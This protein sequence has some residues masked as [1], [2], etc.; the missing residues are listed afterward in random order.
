LF[1]SAR[2]AYAADRTVTN[3]SNDVQL[4]QYLGEIQA[5]GGGT[6]SF[7]CGNATI[8][9]TAALPSITTDTIVNAGNRITISGNNS[10]RIFY[11]APTGKLRLYNITLTR[12]YAAGDGGAIYNDGLLDINSSKFLDNTAS[13]S[14]GAIV[15]YGSVFVVG[16]EFA[17]NKGANGGAIYPRHAGGQVLIS[18]S[19][20][21]HNETTSATDGWGGAILIWNS[22]KVTI[23]NSRVDDNK[24][25]SGGGVYVRSDATLIAD[26]SS[27]NFNQATAYSGGAVFNEA[28]ATITNSTMSNNTAASSGG[29]LE[30]YLNGVLSLT[31]VTLSSNAANFGGGISNTKANGTLTNV[32]ITGNYASYSGGGIDNGTYAGEGL[33]LKNTIVANSI[34]GGNCHDTNALTINTAGFNLSSDNTCT[35][36]FDQPTDKNNTDPLLSGL[37]TNGGAT[38][39]HLPSR[40]SPAVNQGTGSGAPS[41]D[42]RGIPRPQGTAVDIGAVEVCAKP[43]KPTL[44][45]PKNGKKV[46]KTTFKLDWLDSICANKYKVQVR[47]GSSTGPI[48]FA[49]KEGISEAVAGTF[50]KGKTYYWQ[51]TGIGNGKSKSDWWSF[52]IKP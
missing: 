2:P 14:G 4:H 26:G 28:A 11:V 22:A 19:N 50:V 16:S 29:A 38:L 24:A 21:H 51:V 47:D 48:V 41:A 8:L 7:N 27:F 6:L 13:A 1:L 20:L 33:T 52:T 23:L 25:R 36:F 40:N 35:Q 30:N 10:F 9:L 15:S 12:G 49:K 18:A 32:T 3:C 17:R 5:T 42:Q 39:T 46:K 43:A 34:S 31:N 44:T 45:L 37:T